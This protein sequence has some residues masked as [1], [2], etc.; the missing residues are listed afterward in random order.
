[1]GGCVRRRPYCQEQDTCDIDSVKMSYHHGNLRPALIRAAVDIL[2][3]EGT[4]G[5]TLR[6]VARRAGVSRQAPYNHFR[7][8]DDLIAAVAETS[9]DELLDELDSVLG[10]GHP[11]QLEELGV[12]YVLFAVMNPARFRVMFG[13]QLERRAAFPGLAAAADR[14]FAVLSAPPA[15]LLP[16]RSAAGTVGG[17]APHDP[18]AVLWS[19]VHGLAH[20]LI[21]G[22][23]T[24]GAPDAAAAEA[25]AR[26]VTESIWFGL[27]HG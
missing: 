9:F 23:L 20:L 19:V 3:A 16:D 15:A 24:S 10:E 12:R 7:D 2:D 25:F 18:R 27:A 21:D 8:V 17:I 4:P 13:P 11:R 14:V 26:A 1:M 5:L 6:A 22:Q